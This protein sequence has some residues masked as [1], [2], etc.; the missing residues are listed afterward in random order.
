M[1][2]DFIIAIAVYPR[3]DLLDIAVPYEV[4]QWMAALWTNHRVQVFLVAEDQEPIL[5]RDGLELS[6][7]RTFDL[8]PSVNL[9]WIPG[10]DPDAL[11]VQ[12][13]NVRYLDFIQSRA[14]SAQFVT[15]V[16]EGALIAAN[17]GLLDGFKVTTHWLFIECLTKAYPKVKVAPDFPRFVH[18][19]NRVTGGGISSGLDEALYLVK[20][21]A[22]ED[23]AKDVQVTLQ[24]LPRPPVS[25]QI[26]GLKPCPLAGKLPV[27][28][29][30]HLSTK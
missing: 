25:G 21:I 7:H 6:P 13:A 12:M 14:A 27:K 8:I 29:P 19:G 22:G 28:I 20:L 9:L 10:G 30:P 3:A 18:D 2:T 16:C 26:P 1:S 11:L 17:A 23:V 5:T 15:S 24:Y 4:F